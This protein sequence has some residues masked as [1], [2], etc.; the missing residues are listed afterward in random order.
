MKLAKS[1]ILGIFILSLLVVPMVVGAQSG[2][3]QLN[4]G[5]K[6]Y[7]TQTGLG[8]KDLRESV[9]SI[10]NVLMGFLGIIAVIVI[11]YGGFLWMTAAGSE[12]KVG[13]AKKLIIGGVIG[14]AIILSA[15]AITN[16]VIS[17]FLTATGGA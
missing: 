15:L 9:M 10:V 1:A 6:T 3:V 2:V 12:E 14:L 13:Q 11:L 7:A 4:T 5:L 17:Q 8:T 16:F